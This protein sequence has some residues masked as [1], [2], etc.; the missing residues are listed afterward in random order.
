VSAGPTSERVHDALRQLIA[1]RRL[2]PGDH[3]DPGL[4]AAELAASTTPVR[5]AL[6]RLTGEGLV[7]SRIGGGFHLPLLDEPGLRDLYA[8]SGDIAMLSLRRAVVSGGS[9]PS[10]HLEDAY[11]ENVAA[12]MLAVVSLSGNIEHRLAMEAVNARLAPLRTGELDIIE[13]AQA[14]L[15][16]IAQTFE[17]ADLRRLRKTMSSFHARRGR[18]AAEL[19]RHLY[20][21]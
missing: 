2:R 18:A 16:D 9:T 13:G 4:L 15:A 8:W 12:L 14:E 7:E 1:L 10:L 6:N 3:L 21:A 11:G 5:E 20:R 19:L 17:S